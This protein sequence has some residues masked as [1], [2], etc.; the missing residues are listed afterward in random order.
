M[1]YLI[2]E[3]DDANIFLQKEIE[4]YDIRKSEQEIITIVNLED[5]T[6]HVEGVVWQKIPEK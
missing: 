4:E 1:S 2:I 5:L 6:F 3:V